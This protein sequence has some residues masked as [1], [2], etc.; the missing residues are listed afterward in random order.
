METYIE[1][2]PVV[3]EVPAEPGLT[4]KEMADSSGNR[5]AGLNTEN[6]ELNEG[7]ARFDILFYVRMRDGLTKMIVNVEAQKSEPTEYPILNGRSFMRAG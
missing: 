6:S 4:N 1:G 7:Q 5:I 3:G 2:D